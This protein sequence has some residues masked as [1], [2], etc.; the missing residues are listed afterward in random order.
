MKIRLVSF[1][2][3][4]IEGQ[5]Y[6]HDV[7]I[8]QGRVR[9]R[10]MQ[11]SKAYRAQYGHTPL[12]VQEDIPWHGKKPYIGT[13]AYGSLPVMPEVYE[14]AAKHGVEVIALPTEQV[15]DLVK[16]FREED[17]NAILHATC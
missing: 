16:A 7:V 3:I 5:R 10:N 9:K 1:G 11:A 15:C 4:N 17:V 13:G 2:E 8:D 12:S 14:Q 6:D